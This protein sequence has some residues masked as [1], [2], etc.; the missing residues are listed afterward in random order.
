MTKQHK[1]TF[2]TK[3]VTKELLAVLSDRARDILKR[4]F[5]LEGIPDGMTLGAIGEIYSITRERVRQIENFSVAAIRKSAA[6]KNNADVFTEIRKHMDEF[7][8]VVHE[9]DFLNHLTS[10]KE[11]QNHLSFYLE[12]GEDFV[13]IKEDEEFHHRWTIDQGLAEKVHNSLRDLYKNLS[14][15]DIISESELIVK[16]LEGLKDT[17]KDVRNEE[18]AKRWVC[19]SKKIGKNALGEWGVAHSPNIKVRGIRDL[20]YLILRKH[21]SPM[22][23]KEV[24]KAIREVFGKKANEATCHNELIKDNRFVLVGRGLYALKKWG[25]SEGT[26]KEVVK[27]ILEK[28]GPLSKED[29]LDKTMR[30]RYIK[31][32]TVLVNL[33]NKKYF[34]KDKDGKYLIV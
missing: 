18:M 25:Y 1:I 17:V 29:I 24:A 4:R 14:E 6:F 28:N 23:F 12:L 2:N 19:I 15:D 8:G 3:K 27:A 13:K 22:H 20:A 9:K 7:G 5:G 10:D 30:E 34:K 32:N 31:A 26:V 21:G 11:T 33:Q 16:F